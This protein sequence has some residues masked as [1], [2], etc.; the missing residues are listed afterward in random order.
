MADDSTLPKNE[1]RRLQILRATFAAVTASWVGNY[2][3]ADCSKETL[4]N[5]FGDRDGM[6]QAM[7][8]R[9]ASAQGNLET[10]LVSCATLLL[11]IMIGDAAL[12]V[13]R[14]AIAQASG[15]CF[16]VKICARSRRR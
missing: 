15:G 4:Y 16:W 3:G 5:W 10:R 2:N 13:N 7:A 9:L 8:A 14:A 12:A 6:H 11:D 1:V